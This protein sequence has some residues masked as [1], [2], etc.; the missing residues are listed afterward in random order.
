MRRSGERPANRRPLRSRSRSTERDLCGA[1]HP[2]K[3]PHLRRA[4]RS[5]VT[6]ARVALSIALGRG[7]D[8]TLT[9][10]PPAGLDRTAFLEPPSQASLVD[11][12]KRMRPL[13]SAEEQ[14][15]LAA[16]Q[17]VRAAHS[18]YWPNLSANASYGRQSPWLTGTYGTYGDLSL[19]YGVNVGVTLAWN[20][21]RG[22][23]DQRQR[24]ARQRERAPR[25]AQGRAVHAAGDEPDRPLPA[26]TTSRSPP[27]PGSPRRTSSPPGRACSSPSG[28]TTPA[29]GPRSRSATPCSTSP[30]PHPAP[31]PNR[32]HHRPRR[33]EPR[34]GRRAVAERKQVPC[35]R[36]SASSPPS[37]CSP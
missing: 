4:G 25:P 13:L 30:G 35:P 36:P 34:R 31:G 28:A 3:R 15:I 32:R 29:P 18:G 33:P 26:R 22:T 9:V 37:S 16:S 17:E 7:A 23:P 10:V 24:P 11:T 14:R 20:L 2:R 19:Q 21:L 6:D 27:R 8:P 1:G 5:R 12:A